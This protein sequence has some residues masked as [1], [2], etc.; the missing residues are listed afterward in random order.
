MPSGRLPVVNPWRFETSQATVQLKVG[1]YYT[2]VWTRAIDAWNAKKVFRFKVVASSAQITIVPA[3]SN[4]ATL[5]KQNLVGVAEVRHDST[6]R[7]VSVQLHL[8]NSQ[9]NKNGY[10]TS[11]RVN[12]A[13]HELGHAMGLAHNPSKHSVMYKST[14]YVSIQPVD[15][16]NVKELYS[17]PAKQ[18]FID[19]PAA[20]A[21]TISK[22][23]VTA[24]SR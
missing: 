14:R 17:I 6:R 15:V 9:L 1:P 22:D 21:N 11:Q 23:R 19:S 4:E 20:A 7:I 3:Q 13:E 2:K 24:S 18:Y 16:K 12:V 8:G 5:I 10:T